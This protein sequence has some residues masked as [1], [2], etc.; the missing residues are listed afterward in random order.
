M[1]KQHESSSD[2]TPKGA[3]AAY[4]PIGITFIGLGVVMGSTSQGW[5][6]ALPFLAVGVTFII[7]AL[8]GRAEKSDA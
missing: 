6:M 7:L 3:N 5:S 4:L 1:A 8:E 2:P